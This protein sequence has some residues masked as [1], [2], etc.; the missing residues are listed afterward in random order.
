LITISVHPPIAA[1]VL[2]HPEKKKRTNNEN[3]ARI[4]MSLMIALQKKF[5][6]MEFL[7][8]SRRSGVLRIISYSPGVLRRPAINALGDWEDFFPPEMYTGT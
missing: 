4:R 2:I 8:P 6:F 7:V 1:Y 5:L 3:A